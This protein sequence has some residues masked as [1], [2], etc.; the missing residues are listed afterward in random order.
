MEHKIHMILNKVMQNKL[1]L[2]GMGESGTFT[3]ENNYFSGDLGFFMIPIDIFGI[4]DDSL[5]LDSHNDSFSE[6]NWMEKKFLKL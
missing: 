2:F 6:K 3:W 1:K 4:C 5:K